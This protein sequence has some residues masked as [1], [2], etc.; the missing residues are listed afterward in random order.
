MKKGLRKILACQRKIKPLLQQ[1]FKSCW[2]SIG[3][4]VP[5]QE[6]MEKISVDHISFSVAYILGR[7][8]SDTSF[9]SLKLKSL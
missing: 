8:T 5:G 6:R 2:P 9:G 7:S 1:M 3:G 4:K